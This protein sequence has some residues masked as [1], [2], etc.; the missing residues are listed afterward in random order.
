M[1]VDCSYEEP[2]FDVWQ[3][4]SWLEQEEDDNQQVTAQYDSKPNHTTP[5]YNI[6]NDLNAKICLW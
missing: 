1:D 4:K 5:P 3:V 6:D 2:T